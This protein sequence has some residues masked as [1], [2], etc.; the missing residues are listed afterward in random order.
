[1]GKRTWVA[2]AFSLFVVLACGGSDPAFTG[3][4]PCSAACPS[5]EY[6]FLQQSGTDGGAPAQGSCLPLGTCTSSQRCSCLLAQTCGANNPYAQCGV[7]SNG[8]YTVVCP[9]A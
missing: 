8:T 7:A 1:M 3:M 6:C 4:Y 9:G 5:A 2:L